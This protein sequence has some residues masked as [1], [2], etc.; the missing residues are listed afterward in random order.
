M[1]QTITLPKYIRPLLNKVTKRPGKLYLSASGCHIDG[2]LSLV[3]DQAQANA[4]AEHWA[5]NA[6]DAAGLAE[7]DMGSGQVTCCNSKGAVKT[8]EGQQANPNNLPYVAE[9]V[10]GP[11][12]W[13]L[14]A[15]DLPPTLVKFLAAATE[16]H[17][18]ESMLSCVRWVA[19]KKHRNKIRLLASDRYRIHE[20]V[21]PARWADDLVEGVGWLAPAVVMALGRKE[22]VWVKALAGQ[23]AAARLK[24]AGQQVTLVACSD[25]FVPSY[26]PSL[27]DLM[28]Y[29]APDAGIGGEV[30][31]LVATLAELKAPLKGVARKRAQA[32]IQTK[33]LERPQMGL[34]ESNQ[35]LELIQTAGSIRLPLFT[36]AFLEDALSAFA[37]AR[38]FLGQESKSLKKPVMITVPGEP[39]RVLL[40]PCRF[41]GDDSE[42]Y[43]LGDDPVV[44]DPAG[45]GPRF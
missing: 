12:L 35:G 21:V 6:Q 20:V 32:W 13:T 15:E 14:A 44:L 11:G 19:D 25:V 37:G 1:S 31:E 40:A 16:K 29:V 3:L 2:E 18:P 5:L 10:E 33:G 4:S 36:V 34:G 38:F 24:R 45:F 22:L 43:G 17:D 8:I 23:K 39:V 30:N 41:A 42:K 27:E 9:E 7:W 28:G 26:T